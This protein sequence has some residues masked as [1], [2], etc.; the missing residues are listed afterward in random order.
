M[1]EKWVK[2]K[3]YEELYSVSS[4]GNVW[5]YKSNKCINKELHKSS[6]NYYYRVT[7]S[8]NGVKKHFKVHRLVAQAFIPNPENKTQ[9]NHINENTLCNYDSNLEWVTNKENANY[10]TRN[11]RVSYNNKGKHCGTRGA[12]KSNKGAIYKLDENHNVIEKFTQL[13]SVKVKGYNPK[14]VSQAIRIGC[15]SGGYYW[16]R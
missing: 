16:R 9:V 14:A 3:G 12:Y 8:K 1:S 4:K 6:H 13:S 2:I 11:A 10:G 7:L 5:S 15:H